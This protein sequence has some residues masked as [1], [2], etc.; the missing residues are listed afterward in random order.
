ME[1][2]DQSSRNKSETLPDAEGQSLAWDQWG[3]QFSRALPLGALGGNKPP[4]VTFAHHTNAY[5]KCTTI[6]QALEKSSRRSSTFQ[7]AVSI[8]QPA[9]VSEVTSSLKT[10]QC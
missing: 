6:R 7:V 9:G 4:E 1:S 2:R 8:R 10:G 3:L 5:L